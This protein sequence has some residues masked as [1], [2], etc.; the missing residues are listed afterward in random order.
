MPSSC[1][2]WF[3]ESFA[4]I[5]DVYVY[6]MFMYIHN[7]QSICQLCR[8]IFVLSR[9]G[10]C[11]V[12]GWLDRCNRTEWIQLI[13]LLAAN[14]PATRAATFEKMMTAGHQG[15]VLYHDTS[16]INLSYSYRWMDGHCS[17]IRW[18]FRSPL[19]RF[20]TCAATSP[21]YWGISTV[22]PPEPVE[23]IQSTFSATWLVTFKRRSLG[24]IQKASTLLL[25][26]RHLMTTA[27]MQRRQ[28]TRCLTKIWWKN[29]TAIL[30]EWV[31]L[32]SREQHFE[33]Q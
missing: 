21:V 28:T 27:E 10:F 15:H 25:F 14:S 23:D 33:T 5:H 32:A 6:L 20:V 2:Y 31:W 18:D 11:T 17:G 1:H 29:M 3:P 12:F 7:L 13:K 16:W 9:K 8:C 24:E 4:D 26:A 19:H 30:Q 22:Q